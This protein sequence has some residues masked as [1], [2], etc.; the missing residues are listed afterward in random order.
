MGR[1]RSR[2]EREDL[3]PVTP[4]HVEAVRARLTERDM[5]MLELLHRFGVLSSRHLYFLTP[6]RGHHAPF[7][8]LSKGQQRCNDRIRVLYDLHVVNK[9]S[10]PL[11]PGQGTSVQYVWLDRVGARLLGL[12]HFRP[13]ASL[14][15]DYLHRIRIV[16]VYCALVQL[17][18]E[19]KLEIKYLSVEQPVQNWPLVPD[20]VT[21]IRANRRGYVFAIEVDR[22]EK[23]LRDEE[24][25]LVRYRDW[26]LSNDWLR[27]EWAR[28]MPSPR[29]P[30]IFYVFEEGQR[31][32]FRATQLQKVAESLRLRFTACGL[33]EFSQVLCSRI[34]KP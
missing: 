11:P 12:E 3:G 13:K 22:G 30:R 21:V 20:F 14:P 5:A 1:R 15:K 33:S 6:G 24:E 7:Y 19:G 16:D 31:W 23:K 28:L 27:E 18:R 2:N 26:R 34:Q 8:A 25:K 29:F 32:R 4:K 9:Y 10:P 17:E